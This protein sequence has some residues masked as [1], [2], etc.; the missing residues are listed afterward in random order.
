MT[1]P[2]QIMVPRTSEISIA[3]SKLFC[4]S[5]C[6]GVKAK[7]KTKFKMNGNNTKNGIPPLKYLYATYPKDIAIIKYKTLHTGPKS[8][9][10]GAHSGLI[11]VWYQLYVSILRS[12]ANVPHPSIHYFVLLK[13][14]DFSVGSVRAKLKYIGMPT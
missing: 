4:N 11:N 8:H 1:T 2:A 10:G 3:A 7:L 13:S 9:E 5:N 6:R 14:S 12:I